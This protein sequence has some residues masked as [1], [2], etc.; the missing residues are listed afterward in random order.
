MSQ[1]TEATYFK[2]DVEALLKRYGK[3]SVYETIGALEVVKL[4]LLERLAEAAPPE[5]GD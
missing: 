4:N 5:T 3:L 2:E 1:K